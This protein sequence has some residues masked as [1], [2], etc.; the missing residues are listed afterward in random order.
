VLRLIINDDQH[1]I[2]RALADVWPLGMNL[3]AAALKT[4]IHV[5]DLGP[6]LKTMPLHTLRSRYDWDGWV[7]GEGS[8]AI[9]ECCITAEARDSI[10]AGQV[11]IVRDHHPRTAQHVDPCMSGGDSMGD[12]E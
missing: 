5:T 12:V 1:A 6:L 7:D 11:E 2:L 10:R 9:T 8:P 4:G 3:E